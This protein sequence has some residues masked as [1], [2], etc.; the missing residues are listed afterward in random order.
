MLETGRLLR[1]DFLQQSAFDD[2][3]AYCSLAKQHAMLRVVQAAHEAMSAAVARDVPTD[4]LA[5]GP[6][7]RELARMRFW[8]EAEAE[9]RAERAHRTRPGGAGGAMNDERATHLFT[10]EQTNVSYASGPLLFV[11]GAEGIGYNELVDVIAPDGETRRG[12]VLAIEGDRI[13]VQVLGGTSGLNLPDTRLR[14]R[15]A[16]AT[17]AVGI[18]LIGRILDGSGDA[19]RRRPAASTRGISRRQRSAD[20][21]RRPRPSD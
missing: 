14:A 5:R 13:V 9:E 16:V 15:R 12:Q 19:D 18:D 7:L 21:S 4:S 2:R 10:V 1:E 20:Q 11:E 3:D 17:S 8:S 6:A